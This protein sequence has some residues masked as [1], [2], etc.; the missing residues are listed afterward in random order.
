MG[1]DLV[2]R[3]IGTIG[4]TVSPGPDRKAHNDTMKLI[5]GF[6][7]TE[8]W[9]LMVPQAPGFSPPVNFTTYVRPIFDPGTAMLTISSNVMAYL[10]QR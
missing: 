3:A 4:P 6:T 2:G 1:H 7:G 8:S 9:G 5:P 10:T